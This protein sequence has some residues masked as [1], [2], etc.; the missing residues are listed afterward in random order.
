MILLAF[1]DKTSKWDVSPSRD[2]IQTGKVHTACCREAK[3][4]IPHLQNKQEFVS[5]V[6]KAGGFTQ[7]V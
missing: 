7:V 6:G 4:F 2:Q 1:Q 5:A 3:G